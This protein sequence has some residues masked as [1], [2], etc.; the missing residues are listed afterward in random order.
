[1]ATR[2]DSG[3]FQNKR[4]PNVKERKPF[5][6][7]RTQHWPK[8]PIHDDIGGW[9]QW[10]VDMA[11]TTGISQAAIAQML[12]ESPANFNTI[13]KGNTKASFEKFMKWRERAA[14]LQWIGNVCEANFAATKGTLARALM[15]AVVYFKEGHP[16]HEDKMGREMQREIEKEE[17]KQ[18]L[19]EQ[20]EWIREY[21]ERWFKGAQPNSATF[22]HG[23]SV[24]EKMLNHAKLDPFRFKPKAL[25]EGLML[26]PNALVAHLRE[27]GM[28]PEETEPEYALNMTP[29]FMSNMAELLANPNFVMTD[30]EY[31]KMFGFSRVPDK[32]SFDNDDGYS[33]NPYEWVDEETGEIH[34]PFRPVKS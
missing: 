21:S 23:G 13:I 9:E 32:L 4:S 25:F 19:H 2:N 14:L 20:V 26:P 7:H 5:D 1:M 17:A 28:E 18:K 22:V 12:G 15:D 33:H 16:A 30:E 31:E 8:L 6:T 24:L 11:G 27:V 34:D 3:Q 10:A 29:Q